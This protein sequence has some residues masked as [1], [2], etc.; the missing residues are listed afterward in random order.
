MTIKPCQIFFSD[1][2]I[3]WTQNILDPK[4]FLDSKFFLDPNIYLAPKFLL[5]PKI[6]LD[7]KMF[8]DQKI[9]SEPKFFLPPKYFFTQKF[10]QTQ[11]F[12]L[13]PKNFC[14]PKNFWGPKNFPTNENCFWTNY[15]FR[16]TKFIWRKEKYIIQILINIIKDIAPRLKSLVLNEILRLILSKAELVWLTFKFGKNLLCLS[17]DIAWNKLVH[18]SWFFMVLKSW[19]KFLEKE[20]LFICVR[21]PQK[22]RHEE[23]LKSY[24]KNRWNFS[25]EGR[26]YPLQSRDCKG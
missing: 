24:A 8:L 4:F 17:W 14:P 25:E 16:P 11:K 6:F 7:P 10:F 20:K 3:F 2:N 9:F 5:D 15:F 21:G 19:Q 18:V 26:F 23:I 13:D 22:A 12:F 1:P